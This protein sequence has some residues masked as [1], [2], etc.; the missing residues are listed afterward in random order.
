MV[1]E[2]FADTL[3]LTGVLESNEITVNDFKKSFEQIIETATESNQ[4]A[5]ACN[6]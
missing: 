1:H 5:L 4:F 6:D 3:E 2:F